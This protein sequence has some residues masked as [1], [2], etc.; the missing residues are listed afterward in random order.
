MRFVVVSPHLDDAVFACGDLMAVH[1]GTTV[2]TVFT[3]GPPPGTPLPR[4][5]RDCGFG[6][7]DDVMAA[8]RAEDRRALALLDAEP[9]WLGFHDAQYGA[10][11]DL[12]AVVSALATVDAVR[13]ADAVLFPLGLFH[14]DHVLVH[15]AVRSLAEVRGTLALVAYE[16][17][18]Y[19]RID[20]LLAARLAELGAAGL[21]PRRATMGAPASLRKR[22]A[23]ACYRSQLQGLRRVRARVDDLH[24][25][26]GFW[27]LRA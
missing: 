12:G 19:R 15:T 9:V 21:A 10:S 7:G 5:D 13:A 2:C 25:T 18:L 26:E 27:C 14:S 11:P 17:A 8:R 24:A 6:D 20:G 3:A 23:V 22:T 4:W 16:D 1:P